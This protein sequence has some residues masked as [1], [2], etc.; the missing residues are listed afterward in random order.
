MPNH[1]NFTRPE[2]AGIGGSDPYRMRIKWA[3][4]DG[5]G[6]RRI[7]I[8]DITVNRDGN[9]HIAVIRSSEI[10]ITDVDDA[11]DLM[12]TV[13]HEHGCDA[14][15]INKQAITELFFDLKTGLAGEILRKFTNYRFR[16]AII[17][18]F[19]VYSSPSLRGF[20]RE[21]NEGTQFFFLTTEESA[22]AR[23]QALSANG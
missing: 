10:L 18:D 1:I 3:T 22:I 4:N 15:V 12:A 14:M 6:L 8:M 20:I 7:H 21:S 5:C 2:N 16:V 19:N 11:L 9:T 13:A 23:F 17:G